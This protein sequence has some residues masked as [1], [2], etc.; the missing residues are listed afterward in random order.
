MNRKSAIL[1]LLVASIFFSAGEKYTPTSIHSFN[2]LLGNWQMQ[3]KTGIIS[4]S[5]RK[6]NDST[7]DGESYLNKTTGEK[8][9]LE[10]IQLIYRDRQFLYIPTTANQ[11]NQQPVS[12]RITSHSNNGFTAE[13]AAHDFPK[14]I[15]YA[16]IHPDS[17]QA[18][19][20][21]GP[22]MPQKKSTFYYSRQK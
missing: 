19:I 12:F 20:D 6:T 22:A 4:E 13:N 15:V 21:G 18:T 1:L 17:L 3:K 5:W 7:F 8:M 9:L 16:L 10:N 11:N 2:W 14:R